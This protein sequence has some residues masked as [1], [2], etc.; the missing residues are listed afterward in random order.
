MKVQVAPKEEFS[1][2]DW[3]TINGIKYPVYSSY[4][5]ES[6]DGYNFDYKVNHEVVKP[7]KDEYRIG[8]PTVCKEE[9]NIYKMFCSYDKVNKEYG[10]AYFESTDCI[11]W[12]RLDNKIIGG[13]EIDCSKIVAN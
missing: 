11:N 3:K 4:Y 2:N 5:T 10:I 9:N 12:S 6:E 1:V 7:N 13:K 8:R